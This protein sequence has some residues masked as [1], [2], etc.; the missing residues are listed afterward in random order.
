MDKKFK[1][2]YNEIDSVNYSVLKRP[3]LQVM[4]D[5]I[6]NDQLVHLDEIKE[7]KIEI[8]NCL[9]AHDGASAI[10]LKVKARKI[11][12]SYEDAESEKQKIWKVL[13]NRILHDN[14][15]EQFGDAKW[16]SRK[17]S[18]IM[19][20]IVFVLGL[21]IYD[22]MNPKLPQSTK[23]LLYYL[24]FT[25]CILFLTNF[26]YELKYADSKS[27]YW[28]SHLIDFVTSIPLPDLQ[29]LRFGRMM[30]L[31]RL[32][33][34]VRIVRILR[35]LRAVAFFWRGANQ[36]EHW[37]DTKDM[38]TD[39]DAGEIQLPRVFNLRLVKGTIKYGSIILVSGAVLIYFAEQ[40]SSTV[41]VDSISDS[42]WWS[43]TTLLT[44]GFSD[45]HNPQSVLGKGLTAILVITGITMVSLFTAA[46]TSMMMSGDSDMLKEVK[47]NMTKLSDELKDI[48]NKS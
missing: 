25:A 16:V 22:I 47:D 17:E 45:L 18:F 15:V 43:F 6:S 27:W 19:L 21:L 14:L 38:E 10:D 40:D 29:A 37:K 28:K 34:L 42:M 26:F 11:Q 2:I 23:T 1:S 3:T 5:K 36:I 31:T 8:D 44:G 33:R 41:G 4:Y 32:T 35:I 30:R 13:Q 24:D 7:L 46:V 48:K 12:K 39:L 9:R 20:L